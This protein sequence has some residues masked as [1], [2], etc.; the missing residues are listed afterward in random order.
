VATAD[1][2]KAAQNAANEF[3]SSSPSGALCHAGA[4]RP[5]CATG[6]PSSE[7][8]SYSVNDPLESVNRESF[9]VNTTALPLRHQPF[10]QGY[11]TRC[12]S[13]CCDSIHHFF[14]N[15]RRRHLFQDRHPGQGNL[16]GARSG[17]LLSTI[18]G[19]AA[20]STSPPA[21]ASPS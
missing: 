2:Q 7:R 15:L 19:L 16:A 6:P 11:V 9:L 21:P 3:C 12:R 4:W 14:T 18:L 5:A 1:S 17:A 10:A 13:R 8:R 20:S